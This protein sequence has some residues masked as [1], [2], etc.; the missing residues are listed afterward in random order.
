MQEKWVPLSLPSKCLT[1]KDVDPAKLQI[2]ALKGKDEKLIAEI[3]GDNFEKKFL[4]LLRNVLQGI[5]PEKLT[6]GD[7]LFVTIW[8]AMNSYSNTFLLKHECEH[9]WQT[10]EFE[11]DLTKF[12]V[13]ELPDTFKQP[14]EIK[15]PNSGDIVKVN[16]LTIADVIKVDDMAKTGQNV[17]LYRQA[18][19]LEMPGKN[20]FEKV[21]YLE[22]LEVKDLALIRAF[23][24][25]YFHGPKMETKYE[26]PKCGGAGV[27]PV[28]FRIEMLFPYGQT[29][30][31][32]FGDSI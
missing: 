5:E 22:S 19:A 6:I 2:R 16:L 9:C 13:V 25:K 30:A 32:N 8:E 4:A 24:D 3:S 17:W 20:V 28:P 1:Y 26:C 12:E 21:E 11:I 29:L 31:R 15:L 14:Y 23:H 18:L 7:R 10:S 27:M